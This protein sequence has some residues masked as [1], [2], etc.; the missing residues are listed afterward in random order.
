MLLFINDNH[1]SLTMTQNWGHKTEVLTS[2]HHALRWM[3]IFQ[4]L[5]IRTPQYFGYF[6]VLIIDKSKVLRCL[7]CPITLVSS[8]KSTCFEKSIFFLLRSCWSVSDLWACMPDPEVGIDLSVSPRYLQ[9]EGSVLSRR[10]C[11]NYPK[12]AIAILTTTKLI[13]NSMQIIVVVPGG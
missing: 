4:L 7:P 1:V 9:A 5:T 3:I 2:S 13:N 6:C 8:M 12:A 11:P 10:K